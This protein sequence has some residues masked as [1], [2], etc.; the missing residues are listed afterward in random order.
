MNQKDEATKPEQETEAPKTPTPGGHSFS[1]PPRVNLE[2]FEGPLDLL[3]YLIRKNEYDIFD[4]PIAKI[5][6]QYLGYLDI[7][8][9][10]NLDV[11]GEFLV[12]AATLMKIKS[13][14]LLPRPEAEDDEEGEDPRAALVRQLLEYQK[15]KE[16][17][18]ELSGK[19]QLGR[20]VFARN[21]PNPELTK[22]ESQDN[23]YL[24]VDVYQLIEALR[25]VLKRVPEAA[26][27]IVHMEPYSVR[28]RMGQI[29]Q[30]L[31]GI[32]SIAFDQLFSDVRVRI[33]VVTTFLAMLEL[34][35]LS[36]LKVFQTGPKE[37]IRIMPLLIDETSDDEEIS[38]DEEEGA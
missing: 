22:V 28:E 1:E 7:L 4:I 21:F 17:A 8:K 10:L 26:E 32:E 38:D 5:T 33:E 23:T 15:Y 31:K 2:I 18:E 6:E 9:D 24:E 12:M 35:R 14:M 3:I 20:D 25:A 19:E 29:I 27:H 13:R 16:A 30:M 34:V 36:M 11:A 37:P